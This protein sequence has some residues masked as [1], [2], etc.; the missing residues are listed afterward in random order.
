[1]NIEKT[2]LED[3]VRLG[4]YIPSAVKQAWATE[5]EVLR[6]VDEICSKYNIRYFAD[7]GTLLGAVRHGGFIPWDDDLDIVMM[8]E[9][10]NRF[11]ELSGEAL[12]E[13]YAV[14][15]YRN[16]EGFDQF[17]AVV[18]NAEHASFTKEHMK[19]FYGFPYLCGL[20]I[21]VLDYVYP[22]EE[23]EINRVERIKYVLAVADEMRDDKLW[24][25]DLYVNLDKIE[26]DNK[27]QIDR[28]LNKQEL[29]IAL[30]ELVEV[31]C[32]EVDAKDAN[33]ITQI[34]PWGIKLDLDRRYKKEI[35][36][37]IIRIPF[38]NTSIPVPVSY[39]DMLKCRY[40]AYLFFAKATGAHDYPFFE[41]QKKAIEK[42][43]GNPMPSFN[44]NDVKQ[45]VIAKLNATETDNDNLK[46]IGKAEWKN[47]II[48]C[49]DTIKDFQESVET[50]P[51]AQQLAIDLGNYIEE[52]KGEGHVCIPFVEKYC[53]ALF[54]YYSE[55]EANAGNSNIDSERIDSLKTEIYDTYKEL[56]NSIEEELL[57]RR[58][59]VFLPF[60]AENWSKFKTAWEQEKKRN[61]TDVYVV[62]IPYYY[63]DY[64]GTLM[65]EIYDLEAYPEE[66]SAIAYDA[67]SLETLEPDTIYI[68][69]PYDQ[70]NPVYCVHPDFYSAKLRDVTDEL[71]Y[72]PYFDIDDFG[73]EEERAFQNMNYYVTVPGV[74]LSDKVYLSSDK[75]VDTYIE[76]L[77][78]WSGEE[79][80]RIWENKC[81]LWPNSMDE[82]SH[83][84]KLSRCDEDS[85]ITLMYYIGEGPTLQNSI[86]F[87]SKVR[88]NINT[89]KNA[90]TPN[91]TLKVMLV[92]SDEILDLAKSMRPGLSEEIAGA[93]DEIRTIGNIM[94]VGNIRDAYELSDTCDAYYGDPGPLV[95][96]FLNAKK[97]IMIQ[98]YEMEE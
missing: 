74:V 66:I 70:Y 60:K 30:Y 17:H 5:L 92:L 94:L 84:K 6:V 96:A 35:Y 67:I 10:Y 29:W 20:D 48:E 55:F 63:K 34:V 71:I 93:I 13:G 86:Y 7:W 31:I 49:L 78:S 4:F 39:D 51:D 89:L 32:A 53:E 59:V 77:I 45:R 69:N 38:E 57:N 16:E 91:S 75:L 61:D 19:K 95:S 18:Q 21:F 15:T 11:L 14:H 72:I 56:G 42:L 82:F 65:E 12:P 27:V 41:T 64:D 50:I 25:K 8:R 44:W 54:L 73:P 26:K 52:L 68:Q 80:N 88:N 43:M 87:A 58:V 47:I 33:E 28:S 97:P 24:G 98:N 83:A 37:E 23:D 3:E 81:L 62:A 1:M 46:Q 22:N 85:N 36:D 9:D 79:D 2:F 76:K 40:G 90:Q